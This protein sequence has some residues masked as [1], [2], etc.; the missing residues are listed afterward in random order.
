MSSKQD[1]GQQKSGEQQSDQ[2]KPGSNPQQSEEQLRNDRT[3]L[4]DVPPDAQ[5]DLRDQR[6]AGRW[7]RLPK[8]VIQRMYDNGKRQL[9][10]KY[11][12]LLE[13]YFRKLPER[14][15]R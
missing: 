15:Q 1:R 2:K 14:S 5:G 10:E 13:D 8:T 12:I 11:R 9:P 4:G 6:G 3:T 7:G